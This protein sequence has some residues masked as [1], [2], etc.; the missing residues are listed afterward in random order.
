MVLKQEFETLHARIT[1]RRDLILSEFWRIFRNW[2][3]VKDSEADF[4]RI[5]E[6]LAEMEQIAPD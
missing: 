3:L 4:E 1:E 2:R 6:I 5:N